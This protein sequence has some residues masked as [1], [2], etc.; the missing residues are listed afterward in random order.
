MPGRCQTW[1]HPLDHAS[2]P[3]DGL[4]LGDQAQLRT[5]GIVT[6]LEACPTVQ[7]TLDPGDRELSVDHRLEHEVEVPSQVHCPVRP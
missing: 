7:I 2:R 6:E 3:T 5:V 4:E 1:R